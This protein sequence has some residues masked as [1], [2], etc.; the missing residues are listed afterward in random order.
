[1]KTRFIV[2]YNKRTIMLNAHKLYRSGKQGIWAE[3]LVKA[4]E[5]AKRYKRMA[6]DVGK[7]VHTWYGWTQLGREVI[8]GEHA[9]A[10]I[11]LY[12]TLKNGIARVMSYFTYEQTCELGTQPPKE[13]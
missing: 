2:R 11:S 9:V 8:H 3:C 6:E 1:M 7:E 13:T 10:Q 5:N 4:W 12:D